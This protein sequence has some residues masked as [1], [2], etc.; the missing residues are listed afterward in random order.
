M[1]ALPVLRYQGRP[2]ARRAFA[3]RYG[4]TGS[5]KRKWLQGAGA[6][7]IHRD[8]VYAGRSKPRPYNDR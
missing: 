2:H 1:P 8:C 3:L 7:W 5:G 6:I 4:V